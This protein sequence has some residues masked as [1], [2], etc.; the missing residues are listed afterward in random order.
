MNQWKKV[1]GYRPVEWGTLVGTTE[2]VTQ[3]I[4]IRNNLDATSIKIKFTNLYDKQPLLLEQVT[5]GKIERNSGEIKQKIYRHK[6][7]QP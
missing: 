3:R 5:I 7:V 6:V 2:D 1:W 4:Y